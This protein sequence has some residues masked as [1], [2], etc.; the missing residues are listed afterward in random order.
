[1]GNCFGA[2]LMREDL[3]LPGWRSQYAR[4][5]PSCW[6]FLG[7]HLEPG[8]SFEAV[9]LREIEEE[10]GVSRASLVQST[11]IYAGSRLPRLLDCRC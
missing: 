1:M 2:M 6:D 4:R 11:R 9:L 3:V 5:I 7:G 10:A 8:E